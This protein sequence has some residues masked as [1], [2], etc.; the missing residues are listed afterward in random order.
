MRSEL[1]FRMWRST[2][3]DGDGPA[4]SPNELQSCAVFE[5]HK[6]DVY[7]VISRE[8]GGSI[9]S[10]GYDRIVREWDVPTHRQV[11]ELPISPFTLIAR[12]FMSSRSSK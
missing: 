3:E 4:E 7:S 5:G 11:L 6:H 1:I 8:G 10:A 9:V 12:F 2:Y